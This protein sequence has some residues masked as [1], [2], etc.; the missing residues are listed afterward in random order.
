[1]NFLFFGLGSIGQRHL[2]NLLQLKKNCK[3]YA[4][5]KKFST[6]LLNY[7]NKKIRGNVEKK[8][9]IISIKTLEYLKKKDV[10]ID[11]AFICNP[12]NMHAST[13]KWCI[14]RNIPVFIEKPAAT[15]IKD[16]NLIKK[17]V[18]SKKKV[19]NVVGYQLRFNPIIR[20]I[21]KYCFDQKKLGQVY[22]CEIFHGEHVDNF[23]SYESYKDSYTSQ[24]K[25]GGGVALTQIHEI[26]YLN[27]FFSEY[28]LLEFKYISDKISKL[29]MN[30]EDNYTSIFKFRSTKNKKISLGK[31]TCSYVQ[32]PKKRTIFI[33]CEQGSLHAD[34]NKSLIKILRPKK[35]DYV[36]KFNFNRNDMFTNEIK[37]FL[38]LIKNPKLKKKLL[39]SILEDNKVNKIAIK[40]KI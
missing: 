8:Y 22:N 20:F 6:P 39:P 18:K 13:A 7:Q 17:L 24:K 36:K 38:S 35:R 32:V 40:I 1:M 31:I 3:I 4:L 37:Q 21:K 19:I 23:H 15:N 14:K 34:L 12:S 2:R 26:D 27:Y 10:K 33:S 16:L 9:K 11:A 29:K 30:V 25:L 28:K 5:R